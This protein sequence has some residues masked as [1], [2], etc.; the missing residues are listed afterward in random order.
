MM[1]TFPLGATDHRHVLYMQP[2]LRTAQSMRRARGA[3][4]PFSSASAAAFRLMTVCVVTYNGL[5]LNEGL[6]KTAG[7]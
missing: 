5:L 2:L 1:P 3:S 7:S 4:T 6:F